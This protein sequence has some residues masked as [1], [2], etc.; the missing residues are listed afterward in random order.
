MTQKQLLNR[1]IF[2]LAVSLIIASMIGCAGPSYRNVY[3]L[4]AFTVI[5][6]DNI[7]AECKDREARACTKT[8]TINGK[9]HKQVVYEQGDWTGLG[10]EVCHVIHGDPDHKTCPAH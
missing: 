5:E 6:T 4:N 7:N 2:C 1:A 8:F 9:N 3:P 10:M